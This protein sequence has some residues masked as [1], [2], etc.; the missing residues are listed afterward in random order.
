MVPHL[1]LVTQ[2][3]EALGPLYPLLQAGAPWA[4]AGLFAATLVQP[5]ADAMRSGAEAV[6]SGAEAVGSGAKRSF[7]AAQVP[8]R[9]TQAHFDRLLAAMRGDDGQ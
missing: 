6:R 5:V 4:I 2:A 8:V 3:P 1:T 7:A 9:A